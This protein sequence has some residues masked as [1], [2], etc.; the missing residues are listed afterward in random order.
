MAVLGIDIGTTGVK[1][2]AFGLEG[3]LLAFAQAEY[4]LLGPQPGW[5][6]L[7]PARV[8]NGI[9]EVI[10]KVSA[11]VGEGRI[12]ALA[13]S[14]LGEAVL[15]VDGRGRPLANTIV[16]LDHR[17]VAQAETLRRQIDPAEFFAI[18]GQSFHPIAT[19]FKL[20]WWR[21]E[22]P[23]LFRETR[24]FLCWNDMLAAVLGLE[25]AIS[26]SLAARTGLLDLR[27]E[28]W[29][30]R[31]LELAGL[32]EDRLARVVPAGQLVGVIPTARA[33]ELGLAEGCLLVSGGWDQVCAALGSGAVEAGIVVNSMG[34]TDSLNATYGAVNTSRQMLERN[35]TCTPAAVPGLYCTNAFSFTGGNLLDWFREQLGAGTSGR[36]SSE[37]DVDYPQ[38][39]R[40]ALASR[41]P[42]L[43][44]AHF[45]GSGTP[46]MD[47]EALGAV[48][49]LSLATDRDDLALGILE[50]VAQEIALNLE[51]LRDAGLPIRMLYAGSGGARSSDL[52]QLRADVLGF[53]LA[54]LEV[55]EA[56]C[57][58]CAM[59]AAASV[60]P[61]TTTVQRARRWVRTG[62][63][64]EPRPAWV[65]YYRA[66]RGL[67]A[68]LYP[69]LRELNR[70][71][72]ALKPPK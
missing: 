35:F 24:R 67:Y 4:P 57:L 17:A 37:A 72:R 52:L 48:V 43:V 60:D 71:L 18:T 19:L 42:P 41:H 50:G 69:A 12:R 62:A 6:E 3:T 63:V 11:A 22:R 70:G 56:G 61:S 29:S 53:P 15:P 47:P 14:A 13:S 20:L 59:L 34:S 54:P 9:E 2:A 10:R 23:E 58:A 32:S 51:A 7:E 44:L 49:G 65:D 33:R 36:R 26:P 66:R 25:P 21:Q 1:A 64:V 27:K 16:A 39:L 5:F 8:I 46:S 38:L 40:R 68:R 30:E 31:L 45:A 55:H 28:R